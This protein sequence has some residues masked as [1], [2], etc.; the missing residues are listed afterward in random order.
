[1][2]NAEDREYIKKRF[3]KELAG[4]VKIIYFTQDF[5]CQ[6]CKE[7]RQLLEEIKELSDKIE[8]E[9]HEFN[10]EKELAEKYGV[11]KIPAIL[12]FGEKEYGV[13]FFGIPSGYEFST[14]IEDIIHVSK[15]ETDLDEK[16]KEEVRKIDKEVHIQV[17]VTPTCPYCPTMVHIAHQMA[18]ENEKI[19]ADMIEAI[20]FPHLA[21]KYGVVGVPTTIINEKREI[22][23]AVPEEVFM[24][25]IKRALQ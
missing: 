10:K 24:E 16:I 12:I 8:L 17:F 25:E 1:M 14:L 18:V 9:I 6:F 2:I 22:V 15:G 21:Q 5:E 11:D 3:E 4:N 7:T 19:K 23:G 13:R 20:E